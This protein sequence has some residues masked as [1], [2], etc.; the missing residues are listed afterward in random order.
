MRKFLIKYFKP[1]GAYR[2]RVV[3]PINLKVLR[4]E[5]IH[6]RSSLAIEK[7]IKERTD[8]FVFTISELH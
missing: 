6:G 2:G 1:N 5:T 7:T 8:K 3:T 4:E